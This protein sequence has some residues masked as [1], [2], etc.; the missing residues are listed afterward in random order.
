MPTCSERAWNGLVMHS[1][2]ASYEHGSS[3]RAAAIFSLFMG[4][5]NN[6][7]LNPFLTSTYDLDAAELL[8]ALTAVGTAKAAHQLEGVLQRARNFPSCPLTR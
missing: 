2:F 5:A 6:G 8:D 1:A 4:C 7:G 3:K